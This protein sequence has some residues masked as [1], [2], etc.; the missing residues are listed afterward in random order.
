MALEFVGAVI[1]RFYLQKRF[2]SSN[3]LRMA[4]TIL[5]GY[6]TGVGL[7]GMATIAMKLIKSAV[8]A[9]PF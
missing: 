3:F 6:F 2:G 8:S 4:P 5:A 1:G 9:A 7:I